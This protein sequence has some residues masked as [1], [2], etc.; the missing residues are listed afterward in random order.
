MTESEAKTI[1][2]A[3]MECDRRK[4]DVAYE[5][6]CHKDCD[7]CKLCYTQ[8][9]VGEH[10]EAMNMA[11]KALEK[12]IPKKI[13]RRKAVDEDIESELRDFITRQ[14][15]I[16]RCPSCICCIHIRELKYCWECGQAI[17]WSDTK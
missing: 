17:D 9:T 3:Y 15:E 5:E 12:Q 14:G 11:I 7:N 8:G 2:E 6:Q 4:N 1:L 16:C 10:R 13:I